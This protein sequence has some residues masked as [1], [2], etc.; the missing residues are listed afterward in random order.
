MHLTKGS[1][2]K[3]CLLLLLFFL[4][5]GRCIKWLALGR[6]ADARTWT[7]DSCTNAKSSGLLERKQARACR[8]TPDVMPSLVQA[9]RDT[10]IVCQQAFRHR[11]WNCSSIEGAPN[12]TP[13]LLT[14]TREQAFVYAMSAAAAVW[15]LARGCALGNLA[16]CSCAT[17]PRKEPP[18]PSAL[19]SS[20]S[21]ATA[22]MSFGG[23]TGRNTFKWGGCG[24]DVRSASRMAKRF[25]QGATPPG[26]GPTAKFLHA[27]NMH[28][29]RAGRR[30]VEQS[31]TLE[32]K[33][34]GVSGSCSVRTC[35]R[36]LGS[37]G[38]SVAGTRLLRRYATAAEVKP[39][40]GGRLP[41]LYHHDNLLYT[42]KSPDYCLP[43]KKRGSLGTIGR[44]CNGSSTGYEG[45]EYLCCGRG[46]VTRTE[47]ILERCNCKYISCCYVK[48][49][50][51][52]RIVETYECN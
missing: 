21:L 26:T 43:D 33:C 3:V 2:P 23:L 37:S 4:Q 46:H 39:R 9:A 18:S 42:T 48:C 27:V 14:G 50:T 22:T 12:Y 24:D 49:K 7:K 15:R 38:P 35:W 51:C 45:C 6:M 52:R 41:P 31:L 30:A 17:P 34:H 36:G 20:S 11:R 10:S 13:E 32:C 28:N 8:A 40:S 1:L 16:A 19:I 29:N 25:L 44:Q 5:G 47:E